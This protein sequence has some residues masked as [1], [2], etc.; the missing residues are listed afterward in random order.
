MDYASAEQNEMRKAR[1]REHE[2]CKEERKE[3]RKTTLSFRRR[4]SIIWE[5]WSKCGTELMAFCGYG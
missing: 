5:Q 4:V 2:Q 1:I 3:G